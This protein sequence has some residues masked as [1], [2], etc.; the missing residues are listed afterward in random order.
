[1]DPKEEI[2]SLL[3]SHKERSLPKRDKQLPDDGNFLICNL[4]PWSSCSTVS[5][6]DIL[7]WSSSSDHRQS[8]IHVLPIVLFAEDN[9]PA[10]P[11]TSPPQRPLIGLLDSSLKLPSREFGVKSYNPSAE[12]ADHGN[13]AASLGVWAAIISL[14]VVVEVIGLGCVIGCIIGVWII[15]QILQEDRDDEERDVE[16]ADWTTQKVRHKREEYFGVI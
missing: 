11:S 6:L 9:L 3:P 5:T 16:K 4:F 7:R 2:V 13:R 12:F 15:P 14:T 10:F 8:N 1:M